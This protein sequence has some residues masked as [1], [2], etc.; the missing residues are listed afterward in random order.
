VE[1]PAK[2]RALTLY[3]LA[4]ALIQSD[5]QEQLGLRALHQQIFHP[6]GSDIQTGDLPVTG[7]TLLTVARQP[8]TLMN[9]MNAL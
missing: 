2:A 5:L 8:A 1:R 3:H 6:V 4:D 7:T 9:V